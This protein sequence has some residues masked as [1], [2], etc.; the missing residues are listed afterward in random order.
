MEVLQAP[1]VTIDPFHFVVNG[2]S[3]PNACSDWP[4]QEVDPGTDPL[5]PVDDIFGDC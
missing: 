4:S 2:D 5:S 1:S 3:G